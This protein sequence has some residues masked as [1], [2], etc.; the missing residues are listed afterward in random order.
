MPEIVKKR[1]VLEAVG[2]GGQA[3]GDGAASSKFNNGTGRVSIEIP[4]IPIIVIL[5]E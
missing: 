4:S 3:P 5:R 2:K 1:V